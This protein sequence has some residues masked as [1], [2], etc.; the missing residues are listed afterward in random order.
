MSLYIE[1]YTNKESQEL[2][3]KPKASLDNVTSEGKKMNI[4]L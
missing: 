4:S 3:T 2:K 1:N